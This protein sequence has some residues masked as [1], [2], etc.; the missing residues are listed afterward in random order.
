MTKNYEIDCRDLFECAHEPEIPIS[1][2]SE[3]VEWRCR[4]G[5]KANTA[6]VNSDWLCV[7][8]RGARCRHLE[9]KP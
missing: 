4:C 8:V 6:M 2:G 5:R 3:I 1:D 7:R 9:C